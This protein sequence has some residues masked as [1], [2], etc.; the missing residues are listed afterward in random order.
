MSI[1]LRRPPTENEIEQICV[2][3]EEA[4]KKRLLSTVP[5]K[6]ISDFELMVEA[7]GDKPL[8]LNV[9]ISIDVTIGDEDLQRLV[10][11]ATNAAEIK[12][13]ELELCA[14]TQTS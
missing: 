1:E 5:L 11:E 10:L 13:R 3:A 9:D 12:V 14:N 7:N 8:V 6:R 2:A 4:A